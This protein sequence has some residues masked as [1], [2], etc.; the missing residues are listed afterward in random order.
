[1]SPKHEIHSKLRDSLAA[2]AA[3]KA[4]LKWHSK[5]PLA[6]LHDLENIYNRFYEYYYDHLESSR[7]EKE[8]EDEDDLL[9]HN[10]DTFSLGHHNI[11]HMPVHHSHQNNHFNLLDFIKNKINK[12]G[13]DDDSDPFDLD[14]KKYS[15]KKNLKKSSSKS[16]FKKLISIRINICFLNMKINMLM[17]KIKQIHSIFMM[18]LMFRMK[19][20]H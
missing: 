14:D 19:F 12:D 6:S 11:H 13:E 5:M 4:L 10:H 3:N 20:I 17:I 9:Y 15:N 18:N 2:K 1:M 16:L 7:L 8:V